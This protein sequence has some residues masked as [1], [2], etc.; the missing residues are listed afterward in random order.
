M[1]DHFIQVT[2]QLDKRADPVRNEAGAIVEIPVLT[3][4]TLVVGGVGDSA[5]DAFQGALQNGGL[6]WLE[7]NIGLGLSGVLPFVAPPGRH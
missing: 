1:A 2:I 3:R 4:T 5:A 7:K 6:A